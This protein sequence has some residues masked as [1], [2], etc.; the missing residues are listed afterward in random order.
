MQRA[1]ADKTPLKPRCMKAL[2]QALATVAQLGAG[3]DP[4]KRRFAAAKA[5]CDGSG[6]DLQQIAQSFL[7]EPIGATQICAVGGN[8]I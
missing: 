4:T 3:R 5:G 8:L 2:L 1:T 7:V 6:G